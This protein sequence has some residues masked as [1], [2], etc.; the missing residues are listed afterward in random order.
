MR[1]QSRTTLRS[2]L[3]R[4]AHTAGQNALQPMGKSQAAS[5][6]TVRS[7]RGPFSILLNYSTYRPYFSVR[8]DGKYQQ[9]ETHMPVY[10][11]E[12]IESMAAHNDWRASGIGPMAVWVRAD[13]PDDARNK[14]QRATTTVVEYETEELIPVSP[15]INSAVVSCDED[16]TQDVPEGVVLLGNGQTITF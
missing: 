9:P 4:I 6:I 8:Y 2:K 15:W 14:M 7:P 10:R 13:T 1:A 16:P 12:P 5:R 3:S 11:L